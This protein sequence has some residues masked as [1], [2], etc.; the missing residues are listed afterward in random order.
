MILKILF[1]TTTCIINAVIPRHFS[2]RSRYRLT[3]W[4]FGDL[5]MCSYPGHEIR[6]ELEIVKKDW[7]RVA[8]MIRNSLSNQDPRNIM[9]HACAQPTPLMDASFMAEGRV[10]SRNQSQRSQ[11]IPSSVWIP[12]P[13]LSLSSACRAKE[14]CISSLVW[15]LLSKRS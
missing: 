8:K 5:V 13:S 11:V 12:S 15:P 14:L 4:Y 2:P 6:P 1:T 3:W 10:P 7:L 9:P